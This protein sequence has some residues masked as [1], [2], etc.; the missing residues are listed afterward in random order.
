M[1]DITN[2]KKIV[3]SVSGQ[4]GYNYYGYLGTNG[5]WVIMRENTAQT[6]YRYKLG[7]SDYQSNWSNRGSL[8]YGLPTIG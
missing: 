1:K 8:T 3:D 5:E 4:A 7:A 2:G 6:E